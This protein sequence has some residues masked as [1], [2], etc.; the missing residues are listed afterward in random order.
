MIAMM[1]TVVIFLT[2]NEEEQYKKT[3]RGHT[4]A[5]VYCMAYKNMH[6]LCSSVLNPFVSD[7]FCCEIYILEEIDHKYLT[8]IIYLSYSALQA[9]RRS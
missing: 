4:E 7:Q 1:R 5:Y 2:F 3:F 9:K 6:F 8:I